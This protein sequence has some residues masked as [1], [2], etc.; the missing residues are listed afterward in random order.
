MWRIYTREGMLGRANDAISGAGDPGSGGAQDS[1]GVDRRVGSPADTEHRT[2]DPEERLHIQICDP[3]D[4]GP[5]PRG[6]TRHPPYIRDI[7]ILR[8]AFWIPR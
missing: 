4:I 7:Q 5:G 1:G 8:G 3:T 2:G 6:K